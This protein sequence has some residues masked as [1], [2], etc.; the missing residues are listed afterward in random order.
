MIKTTQCTKL[1]FSIVPIAALNATDTLCICILQQAPVAF[2][3]GLWPWCG[4]ASFCHLENVNTD[5]EN[6]IF[7][8]GKSRAVPIGSSEIN[9]PTS[10]QRL[11]QSQLRKSERSHL[12]TSSYSTTKSH[13][14]IKTRAFQLFRDKYFDSI[15]INESIYRSNSIHHSLRLVSK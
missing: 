6:A 14:V 5:A 11:S 7:C 4:I 8:D 13:P 10:W 3:L 2:A 1:N 15:R 9:K 12:P